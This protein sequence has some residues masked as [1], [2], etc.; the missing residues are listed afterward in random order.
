VQL[1]GQLDFIA[2]DGYMGMA[3]IVPEH[4]KP[5]GILEDAIII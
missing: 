3:L 1:F 4:G 5:P 2:G